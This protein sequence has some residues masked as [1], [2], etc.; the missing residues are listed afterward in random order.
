MKTRKSPLLLMLISAAFIVTSCKKAKVDVNFDLETSDIYFVIDSTSQTG[1]ITF[2]STAFN[3]QLQ[4]KLDD[5]DAD[6]DDVQSITLTSA[7]FVMINPGSQNFDIVEKANAYLSTPNLT[8]VRVAYNDNVPDGRN[9]VDLTTSDTDLKH[10][11]HEPSVTFRADGTTSGPNIE[12]DSIQV[13][14]KFKVKAE[15]KPV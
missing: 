2:A 7:Q 14:L 15:V 10:Y 13:K 1:N 4:Q 9:Y 8:E 5:N 6:F 11:L 3:S 12:A